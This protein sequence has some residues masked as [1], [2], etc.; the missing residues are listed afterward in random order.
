VISSGS[1][2]K[3]KRTERNGGREVLHLYGEEEER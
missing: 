1:L 2:S 3:M